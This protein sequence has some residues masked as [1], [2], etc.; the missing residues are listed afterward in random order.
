MTVVRTGTGKILSDAF[1]QLVVT[2]VICT[3]TFTDLHAIGVKIP[4]SQ[5][6]NTYTYDVFINVIDE[7]I[8]FC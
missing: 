2:D 3:F 1:I 5:G 6:Q 7:C 4:Q 8:H